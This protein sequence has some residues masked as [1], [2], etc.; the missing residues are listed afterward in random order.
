[1]N[2]THHRRTLPRRTPR[3]SI[4]KSRKPTSSSVGGSFRTCHQTVEVPLRP[5]HLIDSEAGR[6]RPTYRRC[7]GCG[8][9][10]GHCHGHGHGLG[11]GYGHGHRYDLPSTPAF[12][13][14]SAVPASHEQRGRA[15]E[16][17]RSATT[18]LARRRPP[19]EPEEML[20]SALP[21][22]APPAS[23]WARMAEGTDAPRAPTTTGTA[24]PFEAVFAEDRGIAEAA[25]IAVAVAVTATATDTATVTDAA[26]VTDTD[27]V[28]TGLLGRRG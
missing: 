27:S 20:R 12:W 25:T 26:T 8:Y 19:P 22:S 23:C 13:D 9:G 5:R 4:A 14:V 6:K 3:P 21:E 7:H 28:S 18:L 2:R 16:A 24:R 1:M 15:W 10:H 11:V 17:G